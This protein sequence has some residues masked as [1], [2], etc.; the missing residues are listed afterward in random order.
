MTAGIET[1][2]KTSKGSAGKARY[3]FLELN[4]AH[5]AEEQYRKDAADIE[6]VYSGDKP[7]E[8][9]VLWANVETLKPVV[10][11]NTAKPDVR[12]RY[13]TKDPVA[14]IVSMVMERAIEY[15]CEQYDF[16]NA[17]ET[18][19]DEMLVNGRG[20][21]WLEYV[22]EESEVEEQR[23]E[24]DELLGTTSLVSVKIPIIANQQVKTLYIHYDD[25][26]MSPARCW[27]D[28]RWV[29]RR[30]LPNRSEL[31]DQFG[32]KGESI[33]LTHSLLKPSDKDNADYQPDADDI[34]MRAEIWEIWDK[35]QRKRI[36]YAPNDQKIIEEEDD[37][38]ELEN[39]FPC[40][41]PVYAFSIAGTMVPK[42]EYQIYRKQVEVLNK[43]S[44]KVDE[45]TEQLKLAG[46]YNAVN[47]EAAKILTAK[48][49]QFVP[50]ISA[51]MDASAREMV[52]FWPTE[53]VAQALAGLIGARD[54]Q[55]QIIYQ[56]TGLS[57]IVRG[58]TAASETAT[59]QQLK[60][61]FATMRM[62]PRQVPF[63]RFVRDIFRIKGEL[64]V[65]KFSPE[66]LQEMTQI[67]IT[68]EVSQLMQQDK[69]RNYRVEIETDSTVV[70]D[71]EA[72]KQNRIEFLQAFGQTVERMA[73]LVQAGIMPME[74]AKEMMMF[75]L[76]GF[77][78][79]R[80]MEEAIETMGD[81]QQQQD[82]PNPEMQKIMAETQRDMAKLKADQQYKIAELQQ[83]GQLKQA[84]I[85]TDAQIDREKMAVNAQ[86]EARKQNMNAAVGR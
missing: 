62:Q 74:A 40:P 72:D 3:W 33:Q 4:S 18:C 43:L 85:M 14:K 42:A 41:K 24:Y 26:R 37:P 50:I 67:P 22:Y 9:N 25:F 52:Q 23:L 71:S 59:A 45:I 38:Y 15:T 35:E 31:I 80:Q 32:E 81:Q 44:R 53:K 68:P 55:L 78:V 7:V 63:Q 73:P 56:I 20:V 1:R 21:A 82:K 69:L 84:E 28:V 54:D 17:V 49:G 66:M 64:I 36:W 70:A 2:E 39:F 75:V 51:S 60:G 5:K 16:D 6:K 83:K 34:F 86:L 8:F 77:K 27:E 47:K 76:R 12:R 30:H 58:S 48:N 79:S 46:F 13:K 61:N 10:Y 19:R 57:D 29:A 65:E 11:G